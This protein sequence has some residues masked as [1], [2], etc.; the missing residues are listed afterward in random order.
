MDKF[1]GV[2]I[3]A[4]FAALVLGPWFWLLVASIV[5]YYIY[6]WYHEAK[7]QA[8]FEASLTDAERETLRIQAMHRA[9]A[10]Q[11][12]E[13]EAQRHH[14]MLEAE[15]E[16]QSQ[17]AKGQLFGTAAKIAATVGIG[18]LTGRIHRH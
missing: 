2:C 8:E 9:H 10:Q 4:L 14:Q 18:L 12:A 3:L 6:T 17:A 11:M 7:E 13:L 15:R 16:A 5:G 1:F